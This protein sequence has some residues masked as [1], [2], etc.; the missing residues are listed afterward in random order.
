VTGRLL[1]PCRRHRAALVD[2][3]DRGE[4]EP[5]TRAALAHLDVCRTC[6]VELERTA[7]AIT[8]LRRLGLEAAMAEP[9]PD[10]WPRLRARVVSQPAG[11]MRWGSGLGATVVGMALV[12][13]IGL[14]IALRQATGLSVSPS[15]G[16]GVFGAPA[17]AGEQ[18]R[19]IYDPPAQPLTGYI[20]S[21]LSGYGGTRQAQPTQAMTVVPAATDRAQ[22]EPMSRAPVAGEIGSPPNRAVRS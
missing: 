5:R 18:I 11:G 8:A 14:P 22:P 10:A 17:G 20:I 7:Q 13:A 1:S 6:E 9:S 15:N 4:I 21:L 3:V 16:L 2:F 19:R 12:A